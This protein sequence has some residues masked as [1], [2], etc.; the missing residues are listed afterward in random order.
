MERLE[1]RVAVVTGAASGIGY[2]LAERF[3][4]EGMQVVLA[5]VEE[6]AL[7]RARE[8]L[9]PDGQRTLAVRTDVSVWEDVAA[10]ADA[11]YQGFGEAHITCNNAGVAGTQVRR[12]GIWARD[13]RDWQWIMGVNLWGVI[14]GVHAF[15]PRMLERG[16]EGHIVNTA[17]VAGIVPG[18]SIYSVTKHAVVAFSE[19]LY[20]QLAIATASVGVSVLCPGSVQTNILDAERNRPDHLKTEPPQP[21][22]RDRRAD[23]AGRKALATGQRP[24]QIAAAVV[25]GILAGRFYIL[26]MQDEW[27]DG[28]AKAATRRAEAI[29]SATNPAVP[30]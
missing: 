29:V 6:P 20:Q 8:A 30:G 22:E 23:E 1:G 24:E 7:L 25:D 12:G 10:L 3:L 26:A 15:L 2:A 14:H 9:D 13:L 16:S 4:V 5:D 11:T 18:T 28:V 27:K 19:A 21:S 17:S